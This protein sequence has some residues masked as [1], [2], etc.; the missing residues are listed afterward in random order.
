MLTERLSS[1]AEGSTLHAPH[2]PGLAAARLGH[3]HRRSVGVQAYSSECPVTSTVCCRYVWPS[4]ARRMVLFA[5]DRSRPRTGCAEP[6]A[7]STS[8]HSKYGIPQPPVPGSST[9]AGSTSLAQAWT[10]NWSVPT[11][12]NP[13][14]A[15]V[16]SN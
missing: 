4:S 5:T 2:E 6:L 13:N 15:T 9:D 14:V 8:L 10:M 7:M 16:P 1:P 3:L 11:G 12:Q